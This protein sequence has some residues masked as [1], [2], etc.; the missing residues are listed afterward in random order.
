MTTRIAPITFAALLCSLAAAGTAWAQKSVGDP[1]PL[2]NGTDKAQVLYSVPY[3][4]SNANVATCVSCT[5]TEKGV[6]SL[7]DLVA[8]EVY[9]DGNPVNDLTVGEGV[10]DV[11]FGGDTGNICTKTPASM[12]FVFGMGLNAETVLLGAGRVVAT[13]KKLICTAFL[14]S[15]AGDPPSFMTI[16]PMYK[17]TKQKGGM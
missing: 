1:V 14:V 16:L 8:F 13:T 15:V 5:S 11:V 3:V 10:A 12:D 2:L 9:E 4:R 17:G 7:T 6:V